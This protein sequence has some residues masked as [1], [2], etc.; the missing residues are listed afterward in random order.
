MEGELWVGGLPEWVE[1]E[2]AEGRAIG[3]KILIAM[4]PDPATHEPQAYSYNLL[5]MS[6]YGN[7][8]LG[9]S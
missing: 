4:K 8:L 5:D 3:I 2:G 9:G 7:V 6:K 1:A